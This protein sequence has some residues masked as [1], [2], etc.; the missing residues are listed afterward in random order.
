MRNTV[1]NN[2]I[3]PSK[4]TPSNTTPLPEAHGTTLTNVPN[5]PAKDTQH[6][7]TVIQQLTSDLVANSVTPQAQVP[8]QQASPAQTVEIT[9][10][11]LVGIASQNDPFAWM[12]N[13]APAS[14]ESDPFGA[15][16]AFGSAFG[17]KGDEEDEDKDKE[18]R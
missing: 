16:N 6:V 3:I 9:E 13:Q 14:I 10:D 18:E 11:Y 2:A 8:A 1:G 5:A 17:V 7:N 15:S 4:T 12:K